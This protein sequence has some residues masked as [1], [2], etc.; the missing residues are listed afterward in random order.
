MGAMSLRPYNNYIAE[1]FQNDALIPYY[2]LLILSKIKLIS[3][4]RDMVD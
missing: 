1:L 2:S 3:D 4:I